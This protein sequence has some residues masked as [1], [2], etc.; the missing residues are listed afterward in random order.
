VVDDGTAQKSVRDNPARDGQQVAGKTGTSDCNR[1]AWFTGYTPK[2][3][4]S[5]GL[6]GEAA[7]AGT[8]RCEKD[9]PAV[10]VKEFSQV[11]LS[12]AAGG[13]RVNGGGFPA[14]IWAAYTFN[15]MGDVSKFD[16][17]TEQGSGV[18][19]TFTPPPPP[20][21]EPTPEEPTPEEPAPQPPS[22]PEQ[23]APEP[24]ADPP[25]DEPIETPSADEPSQDPVPPPESPPEDG[26]GGDGG[27]DTGPVV[28]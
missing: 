23:P 14:A 17:E 24:S 8:T 9:K 4:T 27:A 28:P 16:L 26:G 1:S 19:P 5:V 11:T 18:Q 12:G 7:K 25:S 2:L 10:K 6:F 3:V 13:G 20:E 21:P 15:A 22:Q